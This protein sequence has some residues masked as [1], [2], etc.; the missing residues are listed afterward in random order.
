MKTRFIDLS[1]ALQNG[2]SSYPGLP[3]PRI[4]AIVDHAGSRGHYDG[5]AEFYLGRVDMPCNVGTYIDAPFH[6]YPS[7]DDLAALDIGSVVGIPGVVVDPP[8]VNGR[9]L[10]MP[11]TR[12]DLRGKAVLFRTGWDQRWGKDA[13]WERGP[14]LSAETVEHLVRSKPALV[15]VDFWNVDNTDD[16]ARP[17]HSGLLK[18]GILIVE[19]LRGL[20]VLPDDGFRFFAP[21]VPII[22]GASFPVRAFVEVTK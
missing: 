7:G 6:R 14:F 8:L 19:H 3:R 22:G 21:V 9:A 1:H 18:A 11:D 5:A 4:G 2:M 17:A 15:G 12:L 10:V 16:P 13:Y 20:E